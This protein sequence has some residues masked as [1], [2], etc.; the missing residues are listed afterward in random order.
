ML[1]RLLGDVEVVPLCIYP[2]ST[3]Q[4][5]I[6]SIVNLL[7]SFDAINL[8]D[9]KAPECFDI[10][11]G[12]NNL[13]KLPIFHDD[14]HGT[15]IVTLAGLINAV[16]VAEKKLQECK[17]VINGAGAAGITIAKLLLSYGVKDITICDS[18]GSIYKGRLK[19]MN[20][21]KQRIADVTNLS[22]KTGGLSDV[23]V[24]SD[25]FIGVSQEGALHGHQI[26]KMARKSII[27]ALANPIPE[28]MPDDAK[29]AGAWV[30]GSGR[31][32]FENQI[33]NSLVFPGIF[34]GIT[35]HRIKV[36]T[37]EMKIRASEAIAASIQGQPTRNYIIPD[38]LDKDVAIRISKELGVIAQANRKK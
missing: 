33:N 12:L 7:G 35:Q 28:I 16:K 9:I 11:E 27:F 15:A 17:V 29:Q 18:T 4:H 25:I 14:Q 3:I 23:I 1:F 20:A 21:A 36:I 19:N 31:S 37:D 5:E 24:G 13:K 34:R 2:R 26:A 38:S 6:K 22:G 30:Y 32:D 8:E 10:E